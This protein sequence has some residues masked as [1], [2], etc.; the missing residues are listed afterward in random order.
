MPTIVKKECTQKFWYYFTNSSTYYS[1]LFG[2]PQFL[3]SKATL[4][5]FHP[6]NA[7]EMKKKYNL[8]TFIILELIKHYFTI[9]MLHVLCLV[10]RSKLSHFITQN[11]R[12]LFENFGVEGS[13]C[14]GVFFSHLWKKPKVKV[15]TMFGHKEFGDHF[16]KKI[17]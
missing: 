1:L 3:H 8:Q 12:V 13:R 17:T 9:M 16:K 11:W 7:I 5:C 15:K 4:S 10:T 14:F 2:E 6:C